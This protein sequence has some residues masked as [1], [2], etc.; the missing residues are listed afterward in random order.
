MKFSAL[1]ADFSSRSSDLLRTTRPAHAGVNKEHPLNS[2]YFPAISL[3]SV[4][5]NLS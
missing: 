3:F 1:N 4:T 2:G 5:R